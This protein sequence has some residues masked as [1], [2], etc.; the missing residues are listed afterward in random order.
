MMKKIRCKV[1]ITYIKDKLRVCVHNKHFLLL[2]NI[3][4]DID[5]EIPPKGKKQ[6]T[7]TAYF[8][9]MRLFSTPMM[10]MMMQIIGY[11]FLP[12]M[13]VCFKTNLAVPRGPKLH[14]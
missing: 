13:V 10:M 11:C 4:P 1:R 14:G 9:L 7:A 6:S 12:I 8:M 3:Y 5:A 2:I